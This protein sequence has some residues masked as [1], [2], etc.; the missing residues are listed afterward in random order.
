[1]KILHYTL[2]FP[3]YRTGGLIKFC[4]DLLKQQNEDGNQVALM[5]PGKMGLLGGKVS[6]KDRG[7]AWLDGKPSGI[8]SFEVCN[9]LPVPYDEGISQFRAFTK[10]A[11]R[12]VYGRFLRKFRPDV[13]HI[14]T[15]MGLHGSF[16][17]CA[18]EMKICCVFTAHDYFPIC[19]RVTMIRYG[20]ICTESESCSGCGKCNAKALPIN[21][22]KILQSPVYR[23]F[24]DF[25]I[26]RMLRKKHRDNHLN[27]ESE[28]QDLLAVGEAEDY[29][30]LRNYYYSLL[31]YMDLIHYNSTITKA[32][33]ERHFQLPN[34]TVISISH[35]DIKDRRKAKN[36]LSDKLRISY[37]GQEGEAKGFFCFRRHLMNYGK[38]ITVF[39]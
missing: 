7:I 19:P 38:Q 3:P 30:K 17:Q 24:K 14:H 29:R 35:G 39:A 12:E 27:G 11:G 31:K 9:P 5:W 25:P 37:L 4:I 15:L 6:V 22:I 28:D 16:L 36:F 32:V 18:R 10:D 21:K 34:S 8:R 33:Y 2:G 20:Q 13:I 23:A 26:V 1:M